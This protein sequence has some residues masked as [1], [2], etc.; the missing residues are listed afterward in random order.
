MGRRAGRHR[1]HDQ[2]RLSPDQNVYQTVKGISAA[3][4]AVKP[5][6]AIIAVAE[7]SDGLP[8][9][10]DFKDLLKLKPT[11]QGVLEAIEAPGFARLDQWQAQTLSLVGRK[12]EM[13]L[14]SSL[15][16]E[17]VCAC[18]LKLTHHIEATLS[19]LL[20]QYGPQARVIVLPEGPQSV[21][22]LRAAA[23]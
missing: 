20:E 21:P 3:A 23:S 4:R 1:H 6:G 22:M 8:D 12:A 14:Y 2:L 17:T 13:F 10:G 18:H 15:D 7:C 16:D 9:H 11:L 19:K 5:G